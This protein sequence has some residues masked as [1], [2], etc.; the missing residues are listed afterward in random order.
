VEFDRRRKG[1]ASGI[2]RQPAGVY[3]FERSALLSVAEHGY[4]DIKEGLLG[5]L[6]ATGHQV[7]MHEVSGLSAR[8]LDYSSYTAVSRWLVTRAIERPSF[9]QNYVRVGE[10]MHHATAQVHPSANI[11]GPVLLGEHV[12]V[13]ANAIIVGPASIGTGSVVGAGALVSRS[14]VWDD[15]FIGADA[16]VDS[17]LLADQCVVIAGDR[18]K[19]VTQLPDKPV[20]GRRSPGTATSTVTTTTLDA[21]NTV[22]APRPD[23]QELAVLQEPRDQAA[24]G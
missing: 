5:R 14:F 19:G 23:R 15:C 4:Q 11:I 1:M 10:G 16:I 13:E 21:A 7:A 6:S 17:S 3:V 24:L 22:Q 2:R 9:L 12:Q 18:L 8:V 20:T